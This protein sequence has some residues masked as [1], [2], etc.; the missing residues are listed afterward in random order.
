[1]A[2]RNGFSRATTTIVDANITTLITAIVLYVIGTDQLRGFA[3]TL[4]LGIL[5]SMFTA[6]YCSRVI[7][8]LAERRRWLKLVFRETCRAARCLP[9]F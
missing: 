4:I 7:F 1:M 2:I 6:I 8:D 3:V 5:M 9:V